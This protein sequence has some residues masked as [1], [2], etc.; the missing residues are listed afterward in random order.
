MYGDARG[1]GAW[2]PRPSSLHP[3]CHCPAVASWTAA[4][5]RVSPRSP[6]RPTGAGSSRCAAAVKVA[7]PVIQFCSQ[8]A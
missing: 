7:P 6:A 8:R 4:I 2:R 5:F 1:Y 3:A